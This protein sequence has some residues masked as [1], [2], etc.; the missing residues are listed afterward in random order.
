MTMDMQYYTGFGYRLVGE[1][2]DFIPEMDVLQ[3]REIE[4]MHVDDDDGDE[5]NSSG[6]A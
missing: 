4:W 1:R 2:Y 5:R 3:T 6:M